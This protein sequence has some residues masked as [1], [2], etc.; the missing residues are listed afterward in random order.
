MAWI[1][2]TRCAA[3]SFALVYLP[4]GGPVS[5]DLSCLRSCACLRW[6]DPRN[7]RRFDAG[8]VAPG[9]VELTPPSGDVD[10]LL[11]ADC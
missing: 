2:A 11:S 10:W 7:G 8:T 1:A 9:V 3:G 4:C 6:V 5:V